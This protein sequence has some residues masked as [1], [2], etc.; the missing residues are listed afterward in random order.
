MFVRYYLELD[1]PFEK[2]RAALFADPAS[3]VPGIARE[4]D[5]RSQRLMAEVG[6]DVDQGHR[7]DKEVEIEV[8]EPYV[9]P[10]K[11]LLPIT[12]TARGAER[13]FPRLDADIEIASLGTS[14]TQLSMSARYRPP[15][16]VVGRALDKA[17]L[18][19]VAEAT[20]KDFLDRTGERIRE[21]IP[22][23]SA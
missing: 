4:A 20:I 19:R 11:A 3:W 1:L 7:I 2:V 14:R 17:L 8:G 16:G 6:F 9:L 5:D 12:W 18:H 13:V 22:A 23:G 21:G 10:A 15:L